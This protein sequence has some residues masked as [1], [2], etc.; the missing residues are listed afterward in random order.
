MHHQTPFLDVYRA[1]AWVAHN[2][3]ARAKSIN[4]L[5]SDK[6]GSAED[7]SVTWSIMMR[8][9]WEEVNA[10]SYLQ[11]EAFIEYSFGRNGEPKGI[12]QLADKFEVSSRTIRRCID[13][14]YQAIEERFI[15]MR[16]IPGPEKS[17]N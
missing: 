8:A 7:T 15:N 9:I 14:V 17:I 16:V 4:I 3:P 2:N 12:E 6:S 10:F 13:R 5:E 11:R 1:V